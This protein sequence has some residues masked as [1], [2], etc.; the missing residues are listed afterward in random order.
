MNLK[1]QETEN[2][3]CCFCGQGLN[4]ISSIQISFWRATDPME[5]QGLYSHPKCFDKTLHKCVPRILV[6]END[7]D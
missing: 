7:K 2:A 3:I 4:I 1:L 6:D 5:V